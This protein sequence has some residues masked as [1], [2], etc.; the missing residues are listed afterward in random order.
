M[1]SEMIVEAVGKVTAQEAMRD[2][3]AVA[4][5]SGVEAA[6][7]AA[8][9]RFQAAMAVSQPQAVDPIPFASEIAGAWRAARENNQ[10]LVHR[11]RALTQMSGSSGHSSG[12]LLELQYNVMNLTFQQEVVTKVADKSSSAIQ[13]L[14][15][16]Q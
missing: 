11:I 3:A 5:N 15:K 10:T 14:I 8:V 9:A 6:N 1:T 2:A 12:E 13:T 4:M 16:N 7:P